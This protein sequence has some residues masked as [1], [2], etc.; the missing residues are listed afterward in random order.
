[1]PEFSAAADPL[2][3]LGD[4]VVKGGGTYDTPTKS[5]V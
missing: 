3:V 2:P 4:P 5:G 1:M